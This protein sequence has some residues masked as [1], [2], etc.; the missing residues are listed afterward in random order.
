MSEQVV[1]ERCAGGKIGTLRRR[2]RQLRIN[3][4]PPFVRTEYLRLDP[5]S[6]TT[7]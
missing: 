6:T 2:N 5:I 4:Q 3:T 7:P 1:P